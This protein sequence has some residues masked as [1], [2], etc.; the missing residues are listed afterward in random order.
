[1]TVTLNP[2]DSYWVL[3]LLQTP[4]ANGAVV[5]AASTFVTA[6]DNSENLV[7][8]NVFD[9]IPGS[10]QEL[11]EDVTGKGPGKVLEKTVAQA[12]TDYENQDLQATC[13][14]LRFLDFEVRVIWKLGTVTEKPAGWKITT[15]QMDDWLGLSGSIQIVLDCHHPR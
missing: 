2:G 4:S 3:V 13:T 5:N 15:A 12:Q 1:M 8:A 7:P 11:L 10:I 6:W 9:P 14:A